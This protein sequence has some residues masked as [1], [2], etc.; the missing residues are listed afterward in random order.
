M[1]WSVGGSVASA[2][3]PSVSMMRLTHSIMTAFSGGSKPDTAP[4]KAMAMAT[5][6]TLSWNCR[7]LRMLSYTERPHL[8]ACTM[9]ENLSSRMTMSDASLATSV[10][11]MPMAT[12]MSASLSAGASF[13][14][15]PVM[16]TTSPS[17]LSSR[18]SFCLWMGSAR[19]NT[20][21][22]MPDSTSSCSSWGSAKKS[23]PVNDLRDTSSSGANSPMSR[24]MLSAVSLLSPVIM[25]TRMPASRHS[26]S[27]GRT[28]SRGGSRMAATPT[29][30]MPCSTLA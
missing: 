6:L 29:K 10:P 8:T 5:T 20:R 4:T 14:P 25:N 24:A 15:S 13:T 26:S 7:N 22:P 12:P 11:V 23:R 21:A 3:A 30:V 28:E 16:A 2:S 27:D 1:R 18:T 9:E 17:S 19:E